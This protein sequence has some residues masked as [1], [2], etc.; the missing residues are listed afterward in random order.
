MEHTVL[1]E[2]SVN[3]PEAHDPEAGIPDVKIQSS[4]MRDCQAA[5]STGEHN[6]A[7]CR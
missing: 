2:G 5:G 1:P 4:E 3:T 7:E 6:I